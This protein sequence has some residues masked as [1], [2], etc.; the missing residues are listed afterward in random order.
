MTLKKEKRIWGLGYKNVAGLD[1]A[2]RGPLAGPVFAAAV[3]VKDHKLKMHFPRMADSK[4]MSAKNRERVYKLLTNN[5]NIEWGIGQVSEKTIDRINI[6]EATKLAMQRSLKNLKADFLI[7]DGNFKI[8]S[9]L[10]QK[11]VIKGD[12]KVFS[13]MAAGIIAKV[14]RDRLMLK[15]H[16][17]YPLYGFDRH[18]GYGTKAHFAAIKKLGICD[19]HRKSFSLLKKN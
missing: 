19:L 11:P 18:K 13:C 10:P 4:I 8:H 7:L 6:F 14:S 5:P 3:M 16:K 17:K 15:Y 1:E 9:D 2:G 12:S